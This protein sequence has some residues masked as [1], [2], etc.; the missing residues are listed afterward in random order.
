MTAL[1]T[2]IA[3]AVQNGLR[4]LTLYPTQDG[5]WQASV[6]HDRVGWRV[7]IDAD[8]AVALTKALGTPAASEKPTDN[9]VPEDIFA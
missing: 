3:E 4:G 2:I 6:T 9:D 5:C 1:E 7:E 8:P